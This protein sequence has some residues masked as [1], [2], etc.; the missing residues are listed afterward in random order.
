[1]AAGIA[2][3]EIEIANHCRVDK[4]RSL[5]RNTLAEA[6]NAAGILS[7]RLTSGQLPADLRRLAIVGA[8]STA[9]GIEQP[10]RRSMNCFVRNLG[11]AHAG[12]VIGNFSSDTI[13]SS[14]ARL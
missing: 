11:K 4:R 3:V 12:S 10:L 8:E 14:T 2:V 13:H 7:G 6:K 5:C 1:M 9:E